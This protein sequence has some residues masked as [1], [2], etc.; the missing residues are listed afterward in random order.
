MDQVDLLIGGHRIRDA[1][2][3]EV[4]SDLLGFQTS[5]DAMVTD[6]MAYGASGEPSFK[7]VYGSHL[8][9]NSAI[10]GSL[11]LC[12]PQSGSHERLMSLGHLGRS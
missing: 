2:R 11:L 12:P 1:D 8:S 6:P 10:W 4:L 9:T 3:R 5:F 7:R